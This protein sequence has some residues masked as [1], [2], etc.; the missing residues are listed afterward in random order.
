[1]KTQFFQKDHILMLRHIAHTPARPFVTVMLSLQERGKR[2]SKVRIMMMKALSA[3][4][5]SGTVL[6]GLFHLIFTTM[7]LLAQQWPME[8]IIPF[9]NYLRMK[10]V[11]LHFGRDVIQTLDIRVPMC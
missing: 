5:V 11:K 4:Y 10:L 2:S 9:I 6:S 8:H 1:M 3:N 7:I